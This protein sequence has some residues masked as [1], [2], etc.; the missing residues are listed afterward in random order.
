MKSLVAFLVLLA[1]IA[2]VVPF[3]SSFAAPS[4]NSQLIFPRRARKQMEMHG[5]LQRSALLVNIKSCAWHQAEIAVATIILKSALQR[6]YF[7]L[8]TLSVRYHL[9][10][11]NP[12]MKL[13]Q[14]M[15]L[16]SAVV[17]IRPV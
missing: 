17:R 13:A 7:S 4:K 8:N 1:L 12:P 16:V 10:N 11:A 15:E 2:L 9:M 5:A 6:V 3:E 14:A